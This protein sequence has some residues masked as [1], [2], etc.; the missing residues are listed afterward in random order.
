MDQATPTTATSSGSRTP[1]LNQ[2]L[3]G[4]ATGSPQTMPQIP[5]NIHNAEIQQLLHGHSATPPTQEL[6]SFPVWAEQHN[7]LTTT[8]TSHLPLA[9]Q[10]TQSHHSYSPLT[11]PRQLSGVKGHIEQG[12]CPAIVTSRCCSSS[13]HALPIE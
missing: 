6:T 13:A 9:L 7:L 2:V 8:H 1:I 10:S 3:T 5:H 12:T 4:C 11:P